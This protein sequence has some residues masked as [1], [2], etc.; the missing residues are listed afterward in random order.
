MI[1]ACSVLDTPTAQA[2]PTQPA[3]V[4]PLQ[5]PTVDWFPASA[6]PSPE[7]FATYTATPEMR[8]GLG[9]TTLNDS[10]TDD[11]L[12]DIATSDQGSSSI[13]GNRLTLA[14]ASQVY[15]ISL[16]HN[17]NIDNFYAE[18]T[19]QLNLCRGGDSYGLLIRANA[20]AY[21]RFSLTCDGMVY[22]ERVRFKNIQQLQEPIFSGNAPKGPPDEVRIGVW[23]VGTEMRLFI[24]GQ[25]QF[26]VHDASYASGSIGVFARSASDTPVTVNFSDLTIQDVTF[27]PPTRTP[28][29]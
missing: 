6:T 26:S 2:I 21:Y 29:P 8:P 19:A 24:N 12:W 11:S 1:S 4:T 5:T 14:V 18:I 23:A 15:L 3:T 10:F 7:A 25:Y 9:N 20:V 16:R 17:L 27:S 22:A 13:E 28:M